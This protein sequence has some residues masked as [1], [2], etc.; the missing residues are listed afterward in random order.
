MSTIGRTIKNIIKAGPSRAWRQLNYLGDT[1]A[2]TFVGS[3]V[4]GNSYYE[5]TAGE[6]YGRERWVEYASNTP[7][8]SMVTPE[9]HMWLSKL[10]QEPP[11]SVNLTHPK[12]EAPFIYNTTGSRQAYKPYNTTKPKI[13]AWEPEATPRQ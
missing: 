10:V 8:G 5:D 4:L 2:G 6:I 3:D 1:K 7:D 11:T 12:F 13:Q 9:W